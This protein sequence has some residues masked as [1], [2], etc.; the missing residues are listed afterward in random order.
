MHTALVIRIALAIG[1]QELSLF[2]IDGHEDIEG[3]KDIEQEAA[4]AQTG[5][6]PE[7]D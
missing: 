5:G 2:E 6:G 7:N 4:G 3:H 1:F